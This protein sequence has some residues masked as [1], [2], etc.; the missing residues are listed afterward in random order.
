MF[1]EIQEA[2]SF[3]K[4][5]YFRLILLTADVC[6]VQSALVQN[7]DERLTFCIYLYGF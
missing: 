3:G 1:A 2:R 5:P 6:I 7:Q 4:L